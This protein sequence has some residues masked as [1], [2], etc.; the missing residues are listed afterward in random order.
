MHEEMFSLRENNT[1][2]LTNLPEGKK[3][4]GSRWMYAIKTNVDDTEKC[5]ARF[6]A[7]G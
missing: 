2:T 3:A 4:V 5:K 7:E 1:F 6:V